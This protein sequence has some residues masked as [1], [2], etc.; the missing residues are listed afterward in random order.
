MQ[1]DIRRKFA[2]FST[3]SCPKRAKGVILRENRERKV[4]FGEL[5]M[6]QVTYLF[7]FDLSRVT[8]S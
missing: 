2:F 6:I 4:S 8:V 3:D 1:F 5:L 7:P